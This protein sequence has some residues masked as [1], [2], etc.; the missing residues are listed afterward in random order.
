MPRA[1][2]RH[3]R[4]FRFHDPAGHKLPDLLE[5]AHPCA[6]LIHLAPVVRAVA[7]ELFVILAVRNHQAQ[8]PGLAIRV[9]GLEKKRTLHNEPLPLAPFPTQKTGEQR[10][11]LVCIQFVEQ[12]PLISRIHDYNEIHGNYN[13]FMI[14][15]NNPGFF[16]ASGAQIASA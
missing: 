15:N 11:F 14:F 12:S 13:I 3:C 4:L 6:G 10:P 7:A 9:P 5:V 1:S 2:V 16:K 8:R